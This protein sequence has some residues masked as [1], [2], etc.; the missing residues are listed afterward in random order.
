[1]LLVLS[2]GTGAFAQDNVC[3]DAGLEG[4]LLAECEEIC[5]QNQCGSDQNISTSDTCVSGFDT[6]VENS[7]GA[8]VPCIPTFFEGFLNNELYCY[9]NWK[10][11]AYNECT[12]QFNPEIDA[13]EVVNEEDGVSPYELC[14]MDLIAQFEVCITNMFSRAGSACNSTIGKP[15]FDEYALTKDNAALSACMAG[16]QDEVDACYQEAVDNFYFQ[17]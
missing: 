11:S 5:V 6:Y 12:P 9:A 13:Y 14:S 16:V 4:S 15:C 3:T 2:A 17:K 7:N 1:M 8:M 10:V